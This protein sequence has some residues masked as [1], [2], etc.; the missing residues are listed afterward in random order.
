MPFFWA[1][2]LLATPLGC[3]HPDQEMDQV[4][5]A[6]RLAGD[7]IVVANGGRMELLFYDRERVI[8]PAGPSPSP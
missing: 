2:L 8:V 7:Q 1:M 4:T 6:V 3:E 5:G